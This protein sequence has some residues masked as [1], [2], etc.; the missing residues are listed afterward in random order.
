MNPGSLFWDRGRFLG[1]LSDDLIRIGIEHFDAQRRIAV[2]RERH[3]FRGRHGKY[4]GQAGWD[5][6]QMKLELIPDRDVADA[7]TL[8]AEK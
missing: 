5:D 3:R 8:R 2:G 1:N 6:H 7:R 4:E